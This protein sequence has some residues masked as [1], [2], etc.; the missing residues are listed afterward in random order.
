MKK[1]YMRPVLV[2]ESFQL[3]AAVAASCSSQGFFPIGHGE[4]SCTAFEGQFFNHQHC[5][6]DLTGSGGDGNDTICYHGPF[7]SG[8]TFISS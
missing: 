2:I 8:L 5:E 1:T 6:M 3:D 4:S 7:T